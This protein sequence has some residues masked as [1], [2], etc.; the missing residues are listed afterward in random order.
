MVYF[1]NNATTRVFDSVA[2]LM[3]IYLTECYAN[4]AS[5]ISQFTG[6]SGTVATEKR[7]L[8]EML[9]IEG[10]EQLII[11]SGATES[12]NLA[13]FGA[14][15]ANR[16]RRHVVVSAIEHPSVLEV[17]NALREDGYT[18]SVLSARKNGVVDIEELRRVLSAD[19]ALVSV[20][21]VNNETGV[22]QPI[23]AVARMVK[24]FDSSII[25]HSD[26]T[27]A[28]GKMP[29]S[30]SVEF[31]DVDLLSF[32]AHKFH[33]PKG[34]GGLFVRDRSNL[35]PIFFGGSQQYGMRPGTENTAGI[36]GMVAALAIVLERAPSLSTVRGFRDQLEEAILSRRPDAL[37]LGKEAAR[38][39]TTLNVCIPGVNA[40]DLVD[41]MATRGIAISTGAA[42]SQ[43]VQRPSHVAS[44]LGLS[45]ENA[46]NCIRISLSI[47]STQTEVNTFLK[48]WDEL[49]MR[50]EAQNLN[51]VNT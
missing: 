23:S 9:G 36:I 21:M 1:D 42:C 15:N 46:K 39:P 40:D 17:A 35:S 49:T 47:E 41:K 38:L 13:L 45:H 27:Q 8:C 11:T 30:M 6:V 31:D 43:G 26:A 34:V 44:A 29:I 12:N 3:R 24:D 28:V 14:I 20:M 18:I 19:T 51:E 50:S 22:I 2:D 10:A 5:P 33:G 16:R 37:V 48:E 25:V 32:S 4:A 7:R